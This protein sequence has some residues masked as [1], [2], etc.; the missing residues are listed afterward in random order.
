MNKIKNIRSKV[1]SRCDTRKEISAF[2]KQRV[3]GVYY[4]KPYCSGCKSKAYRQRK[5]EIIKNIAKK[6]KQKYRENQLKMKLE[7]MQH[8]NQTECKHCGYNNI[9]ALSFHHRNP[10]EK[11]FNIS[12]G[13]THSYGLDLMKK[14]VEKC[15]VLCLN[16]HCIE[17]RIITI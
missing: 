16:C 6:C 15:D 8:I 10:K 12:K 5:P 13:F 11:E 3:K 14:E 4:Y 7:L 2:D 9:L 1:C 17:H